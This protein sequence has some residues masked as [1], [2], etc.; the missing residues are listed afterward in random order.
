MA[1][2]SSNYLLAFRSESNETVEVA[3]ASDNLLVSDSQALCS[4]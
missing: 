1:R 4:V 2:L 3:Q